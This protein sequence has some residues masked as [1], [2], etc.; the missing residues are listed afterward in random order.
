ME[1]ADTP[2]GW[3]GTGVMG[4]AMCGHLLAAGH[5][6]T[7]HT[8]TRERAQPLLDAGASWAAS[9]AGAARGAAV[10]CTMVGT[11][12]DVRAVILGDEGVLAAAGRGTVLVDMTT[13]E[14]A[15][16]EEIARAASGRG[17][18][19]LDAPVSG[20]DVGARAATLSIM[21]GGAEEAF[22]RVRPLLARLGSTIVHQG[23]AGAGQHTKVV[24]QLLVAGVLAG[25][26][27]GFVYGRAA[28]LDPQRVLASVAGGAA[29]SWSL[30]NYWPRVLEEDLE[31]GF[32]V[33][34]FVKDLGI[35]LSEG[36]RLGVAVPAAALIRELYVA[37]E[38]QGD[39]ALG[40]HALPVCLTR[41]AGGSWDTAAG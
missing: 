12:A 17:V 33:E 29:G 23:G 27:E 34:H 19:A 6:V 10:V 4:A 32:A 1:P 26:S 40:V 15:L 36:R 8:R 24:N 16:A 11:P 21:V 28:G 37:L 3:I 22:E 25:L 2:V 38:A 5:P 9:P 35:A 30:D 14:P 39:G 41:L 20:G 7:V 13:S 31:P 18:A